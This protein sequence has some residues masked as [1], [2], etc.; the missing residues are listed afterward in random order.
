MQSP[1]SY[2]KI[3]HT[4]S[5][6]QNIVHNIQQRP[7]YRIQQLT[8]D[9]TVRQYTCISEVDPD[10]SIM[11]VV[12]FWKPFVLDISKDT[13]TYFK[14]KITSHGKKKND[15]DEAENVLFNL[16][17]LPVYNLVQKGVMSPCGGAYV[18]LR[19]CPFDFVTQRN[20]KKYSRYR[21]LDNKW[22]K[23]IKK[24]RS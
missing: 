18:S 12:L 13:E 7:L 3:W 16:I 17:F 9:N 4:D 22:T 5:R 24:C 15:K 21:R 19:G 14:A 1:L 23:Y 20:K 6:K 8:T 2:M 10:L 11:R